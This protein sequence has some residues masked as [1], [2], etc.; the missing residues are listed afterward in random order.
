[1]QIECIH[2]P[3]P[4]GAAIELA[5]DQYGNLSYD[6]DF[7]TS[8]WRHFGEATASASTHG[9]YR[10]SAFWVGLK[11]GHAISTKVL[12]RVSAPRPMKELT[13][14]A[15]VMANSTDLGGRATL[16][17]GPRGGEPKWTASTMGRHNGPLTLVVPSDELQE[18]TELDVIVELHSTSGVE[19][20][21]K[22]CATLDSLSIRA[23]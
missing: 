3:P 12:Q 6:D 1:L 2:E 8:R 18:L 5:A 9:G 22:A 23:R 14:T 16:K 21:A 13:V 4:A 10:E 19:Q 17:I 7:S 11:G 20:G 15:N